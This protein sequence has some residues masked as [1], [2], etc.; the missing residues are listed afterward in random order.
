MR[1]EVST[2]EGRGGW[3]ADCWGF[4]SHRN[5]LNCHSTWEIIK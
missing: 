1:D 2:W 3:D 5:N 4:V